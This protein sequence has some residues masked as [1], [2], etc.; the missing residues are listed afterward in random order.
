M[1]FSTKDRWDTMKKSDDIVLRKQWHKT[2]LSYY[3]KNCNII[4]T[5][6][7]V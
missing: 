1:L 5:K 2:G 6:L 4:I 3:C 7:K